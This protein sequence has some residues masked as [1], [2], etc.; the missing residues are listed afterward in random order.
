MS[1]GDEG[2]KNIISLFGGSKDAP[3]VYETT[4]NA[5]RYTHNACPHKGPYVVDRKLSTVECSDCGALLNPIYVLEM[6]ACQETYW[7]LRRRDL[8]D[9]LKEVNK[10]LEE[11]TRTRCTHCGNLTAIR[12]KK[13]MPKTW[14]PQP[15]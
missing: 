4:I 2:D 6:L 9:Y 11:R 13:E 14:V 12:F 10:E 3:R 8:T 15:Y 5:R 1:D 7:N